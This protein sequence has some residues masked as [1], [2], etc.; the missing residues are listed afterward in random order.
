[1]SKIGTA[2][3]QVTTNSLVLCFNQA[4]AK[5]SRG[6]DEYYS[7]LGAMVGSDAETA[8]GTHFPVSESASKKRLTG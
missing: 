8:V 7:V 1:M 2:T 4:L 5:T 3:N 6:Y